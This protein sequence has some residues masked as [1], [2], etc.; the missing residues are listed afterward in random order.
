MVVI[1]DTLM[2]E[3]ILQYNVLNQGPTVHW[4]AKPPHEKYQADK[5]STLGA[6]ISKL[7]GNKQKQADGKRSTIAKE[8]DHPEWVEKGPQAGR[9]K[10]RP[11]KASPTTGVNTMGDGA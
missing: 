7:Q 9:K 1:P 2:A 10:S 3:A 5:L 11:W 8:S 4:M 6:I